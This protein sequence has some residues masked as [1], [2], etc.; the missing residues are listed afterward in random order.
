MMPYECWYRLSATVSAISWSAKV[1][2]SNAAMPGRNLVLHGLSPSPS[3]SGLSSVI[4]FGSEIPPKVEIGVHPVISFSTIHWFLTALKLREDRTGKDRFRLAGGGAIAERIKLGLS[5]VWG[6][7]EF[8]EPWTSDW[9]FL[10]TVWLANAVI[11][12]R[13]RW[14]NVTWSGELG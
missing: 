14:A 8:L 12:R 6:L 9:L 10:W 7:S 2:G 13:I 11:S 3:P 4:S 5:F 1:S